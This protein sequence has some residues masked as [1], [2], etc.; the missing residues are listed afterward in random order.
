M[1]L[2]KIILASNSPRRR[3][4]LETIGLDFRIGNIVEV[5]EDFDPSLPPQQ[6]AQYLSQKKSRAYTGKIAPDEVLLTADTIVTVDGEILGK[7]SSQLHAIE[8]IRKLSGR[9][10]TVIT[11][12]TLRT[13]ANE[14]TMAVS[15]RVT[16]NTLRTETI[17]HYVTHYNPLD[18]AGAYGIQ[19]WIGLV[20]ISSIEG[21]YH[22]VVGLPTAQLV[23][24]LQKQRERQV[25]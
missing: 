2:P 10:H 16:F 4:M 9:T 24:W 17:E 1:T 18:K 19:E 7:P 22:N 8:M 21:S 3:E 11:A 23:E 12:M 25:L 5:N 20:G 13:T 14:H 15:T 6:V